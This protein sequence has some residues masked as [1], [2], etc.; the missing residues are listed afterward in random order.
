MKIAWMDAS[1][2]DNQIRSGGAW[3]TLSRSVWTT[4]E[5]YGLL[6]NVEVPRYD[7]KGKKYYTDST[8]G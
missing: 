2:T 5:R 8:Y 1:E 3:K 4:C 7:V 6:R